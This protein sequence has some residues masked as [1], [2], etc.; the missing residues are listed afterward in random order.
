MTALSRTE[1]GVLLQ[2]G[3]QIAVTSRLR[4]T[5]KPDHLR[6]TARILLS[7]YLNADPDGLAVERHGRN[8]R[9]HHGEREVFRRT[10]AAWWL[11]PADGGPPGY[12]A[13]SDFDAVSI[14][15]A[16]IEP[17]R[18]WAE[19]YPLALFHTQQSEAVTAAGRPAL[20]VPI[21]KHDTETWPLRS[22]DVDREHGVILAAATVRER[23]EVAEISFP[24]S[25]PDPTWTGP[26]ADRTPA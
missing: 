23:I 13:Q 12:S 2:R 4:Y 3:D 15:R 14:L 1:L 25:L 6:T 26:V 18:F 21:F 24:D 8:L 11:F 17:Y 7:P 20:R 16:M 5:Q 19:Q 22:V 9:L 10:P